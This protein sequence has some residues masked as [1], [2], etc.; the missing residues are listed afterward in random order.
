MNLIRKQLC[1]LAVMLAVVPMHAALAQAT[2]PPLQASNFLMTEYPDY[3]GNTQTQKVT[4]LSDAG[5]V[6]KLG[7]TS[8]GTS[9]GMDT[10]GQSTS[11]G[12]LYTGMFDITVRDGY[13]VTG[14]S[15]AATLVGVLQV[16]E[17]PPGTSTILPG[18][19]SNRGSLEVQA[20]TAPYGQRIAGESFRQES[21][22]GTQNVLLQGSGVSLTDSFTMMITGSSYINAMLGQY[23]VT[24]D[25]YS[26]DVSLPAY[27][28][29]R[30]VNPTLTIFT[31]P[32]PEPGSYAMLLAG[33][34]LCGA[35]GLR[36][37]GASQGTP[38]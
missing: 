14:F 7:M 34:A 27:A 18:S 13:R 23:R 6:T 29:Y 2:M 12:D 16:A 25:E 21:L 36:R 32:V 38:A 11:N 9:L 15:F 20:L 17:A 26:Y 3:F 37:R 10:A 30:I 31:S 22:N 1:F 24:G 33:L 19:A 4:L 5:G 8:L 35:A 28:S